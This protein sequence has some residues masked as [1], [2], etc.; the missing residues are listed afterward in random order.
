MLERKFF[1]CGL[2]TDRQ[3][4][5]HN[6]KSLPGA[7][8]TKVCERKQGNYSYHHNHLH[9][10]DHKE[11]SHIILTI[12]RLIRAA[13]TYDTQNNGPASDICKIMNI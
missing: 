10:K 2:R 11:C 3:Q 1:Y 6:P 8:L 13:P 12:P 5:S 7:L 4:T 9:P